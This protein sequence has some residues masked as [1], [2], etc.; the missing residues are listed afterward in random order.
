M[1]TE[2]VDTLLD[3]SIALGYGDLGLELRRRLPGWPAD[4]P[5]MDGRVAF[6]TGAASGIGL[7]ACRGFARLGA[8][9]RPVARNHARAREAANQILAAAPDAD[10]LPLAC[11]LSNLR[12]LRALADRLLADQQRLD[13]VVHNAGVMPQHRTRSPDGHELMFATHV[14]APF[15]LNAWLCGESAWSVPTRIITV[16]SGGMY[17]QRLPADHPESDRTA[18]SP[19]K[20]YARTKR[21]QVVLSEM[22]AQRLRDRG[23][24]VHAMHPG[25]VETPGLARS[26]RVFRAATRPI[27]RTP[28]EGADTIVWLGGAPQALESTGHFW[29]DR[30]TRPTHYLL[31]APEDPPEARQRLW[32]YCQA[33]LAH[34]LG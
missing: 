27:L 24:V 32:D 14:L 5:R 4:P 3:R 16:S 13:V 21:Q 33:A 1:A 18:Y 34:L 25:W 6:V 10:V 26:M 31:G 9:V 12:A 7:A 11:D 2:V 28:D 23:V 8:S 17:S 20:L 30:R 22:W 29:Q 19:S 15:A